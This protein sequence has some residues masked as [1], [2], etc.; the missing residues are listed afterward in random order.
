MSAAT[1]VPFANALIAFGIVLIISAIFALQYNL[2]GIYLFREQAYPLGVMGV[3]D[4][5]AGL[6]MLKS[7][8]EYLK[9]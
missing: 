4:F 8:S 2:H 7:E 5:L 1:I 9:I 3:G 6:V